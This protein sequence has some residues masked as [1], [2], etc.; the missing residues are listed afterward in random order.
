MKNFRLFLFSGCLLFSLT[1]DAQKDSFN[2]DSIRQLKEVVIKAHFTEQPVLRLTTSVG[3]LSATDLEKTLN[4]TLLPAMNSVAGVRMEE[5]SPGSYRL[6]LRG[7]LLRSPFGVRNVKVYFDEVPLTDAGGNTYLNS[8]APNSMESINILK[9]PDGSIFGANS[10]GVVQIHPKGTAALQNQLQAEISRGSFESTNQSINFTTAVSQKYGFNI[11]QSFQESKGYRDHSAMK[12]NFFQTTQRWFYSPNNEIRFVGFYSDLRYQTPGG[13]TFTQFQENPK[14]ARPAAGPNPGAEEQQAQIINKTLFGG[15]IHEARINNQVKHVFALFGSHTNFTNPFITNFERRKER[16][17]GLRTY[18]NYH[19]QQEG[20]FS[21]QADLGF[22]LQKGAHSIRNYDNHQGKKG[23]P[24]AFDKI[25]NGQ[26]FYFARL[27]GD[28][29]ERLYLE[30]SISLNYNTFNYK[31]NYPEVQKEFSKLSYQPEWMPR[32]AASYLLDSS[33]SVRASVARGY[34]PPTTAEVRSSDNQINSLLQAETGWNYET[35]FRFHKPYLSVD[36]SVF[37]Y[38]MKD[39]IIRQL[40][41]NG[42]EY[43]NNAGE[44]KQ[45]GIELALSSPIIV[46][47]NGSLIQGLKVSSSLTL[48]HFKFD[49]YISGGNDFSGNR[50]TGVPKTMISNSLSI[51]FPADISLFLQHYYTSSIPLN[52]ANTAKAAAYNV[53]QA[54]AEWLLSIPNNIQLRLFGAVDNILN[55]KYSLGND[56]NAFGNRFYNA[57]PSRNFQFGLGIRI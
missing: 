31:Q 41:D 23:D 51:D 54:K 20:E 24:Q 33:L 6:S 36:A 14:A 48:S 16:N 49:T 55:E 10:G 38:H 35:G 15:I 17:G 7:S 34:S 28:L 25:K 44:I 52:D 19:P 57:A 39:G 43:F 29:R 9:G 3:V 5:R 56:I 26:H 47:Q 53:F 18:I 1:A 22:E 11:Q 12:R 50:L 8:L 27:S 21:W 2:Q 37:T 32:F 13:L 40:R 42:A 45:T 30:A 4:Q 46:A